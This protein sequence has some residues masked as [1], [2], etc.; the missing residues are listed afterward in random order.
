[1]TPILEPRSDQCDCFVFVDAERRYCIT[2]KGCDFIL[3][4][5]HKAMRE[6]R[7]T[8]KNSLD[9]VVP[10]SFFPFAAPEDPFAS[11]LAARVQQKRAE[12]AVERPVGAA[13]AASAA[14]SKPAF[15]GMLSSF[16]EWVQMGVLDAPGLGG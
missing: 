1:M 16:G 10:M 3:S 14:A 6:K 13:A 11:Q 12:M 4:L 7:A 5:K 15:G 8:C 9:L 2:V